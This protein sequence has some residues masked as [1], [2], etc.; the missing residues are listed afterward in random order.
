MWRFNVIF[1][2]DNLKQIAM[3]EYA[4]VILPKMSFS[5][6]LFRK[7]LNKCI[8]WVEADQLQE[9]AVW[10]YSKFKNLYPDV[11]SEAFADI[12]A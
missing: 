4:K 6:E 1:I 2:T 8:S 9:L 10:C 5:R 7:E 12:A 11:L 3:L